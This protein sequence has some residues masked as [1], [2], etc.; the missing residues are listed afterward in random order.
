MRPTRFAEKE[1]GL[2]CNRYFP[3][4]HPVKDRWEVRKWFSLQRKR[5]PEI[6]SELIYTVKLENDEG[7]DI[8]YR[9]VDQDVID[10]MRLGF[11]LATKVKELDAQIEWD[12]Q[13]MQEDEA[14][15]E[16]WQYRQAAKSIWHHF[17]EPTVDVGQRG[18]R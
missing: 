17:K 13:R 5:Y 11:Y 12:N 4:Y 18:A 7:Q 1:L 14:E 9:E 2:I 8:G 15:E 6:F 16:E 10:N 3:Y